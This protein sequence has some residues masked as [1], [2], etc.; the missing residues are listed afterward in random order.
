M[1]FKKKLFFYI[2][3][4]VL[5]LL[6]FELILSFGCFFYFYVYSNLD[7]PEI[8]EGAF[9]ILFL[10][11][12]TTEGVGVGKE[13]AYATQV[14]VILQQKY[15]D[16]KVRSYNK[17]I[18]SIKMIAILRNLDKDMVKYKPH[19]VILMAGFNDDFI[20]DEDIPRFERWYSNFELYRLTASVR[21]FMYIDYNY[22]HFNPLSRV[23]YNLDSVV[24]KVHS[25]GSE[26]WFAGYLQPDAGG[27]VNP[28]LQKVAEENNIDYVGDY[29]EVD[30]M[31][32]RSLFAEDGWHPS[33]EGHR[34]IAEKIA[35]KMI[36][37]GVIDRWQPN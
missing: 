13:N 11:E 8:E 16:K 2:I 31:V 35:E 5:L 27:H 37:E 17:G 18:S 7:N 6:F 15:P 26:I 33:V 20:P 21:D 14:E 12:S 1:R 34:I 10:G 30:F 9:R 29:P 19:L 25:Y 23:I 32:N 28:V 22:R 36:G 24:K 3:M 4:F